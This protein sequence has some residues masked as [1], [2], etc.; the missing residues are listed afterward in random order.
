MKK[1]Q[2]PAAMS[3]AEFQAYHASQDE[4]N[5]HR[6]Q[7]KCVEWFREKY[8]QLRIAA[9][10]NGGARDARTGAMLKA[11][12]VLAGMPDLIVL[13]PHREF[14]GLFIEMKVRDGRPSDSQINMHT[15]L[16]AIGYEVIMPRTKLEFQQGVKA[17]LKQ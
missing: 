2:Q 1:Q 15:Y 11:E 3:A 6:L 8:P 7:K 5:E 13:Y 14:G 10:P 4:Q 12:G 9:I 16:K 17:Y